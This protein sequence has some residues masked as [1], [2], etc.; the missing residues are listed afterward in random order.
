[1]KEIGPII[2]QLLRRNKLWRGYQQYQLV[3]RWPELVGRSI[4]EVS[5]AEKVV[6]GIMHVCVKDSVWSYHLSLMKPRFIA[7]LN[8]SAGNTII[9]DIYFKIGPLEKEDNH[10]A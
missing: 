4:A 9:K 3:Q 7:K 5:R 10:D 1:M 6:G 8:R 2:E